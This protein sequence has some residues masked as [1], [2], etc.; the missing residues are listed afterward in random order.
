MNIITNYLEQTK[1]N[2]HQLSKK[3]GIP[4]TTICDICTGKTPLNKCSAEN[5]Y[6]LSKA[7]GISCDDIIASACSGHVDFENFKSNVCHELKRK[8]DIQFI[9]DTLESN[10]IPQYFTQLRYR[11][12]L[13]LLDMLDYVS[14]KNNIPWCTEY[15]KYRHYYFS[16]PIYP[17]SLLIRAEATHNESIKE[18]ALK[19]AIPEFKRSNIVENEVENVC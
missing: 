3:S 16:E 2:K 6:K 9:K 12:A 5:I 17:K 11:E 1:T 8:G 4:Y 10:L 15:E 7:T 18:D 19:N 14:R 13:Y